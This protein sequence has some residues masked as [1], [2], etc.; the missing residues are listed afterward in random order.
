M[1]SAPSRWSVG[2]GVQA[3]MNTV[4]DS[5]AFRYALGLGVLLSLSVLQ[6][7]P[8]VWGGGGGG[9]YYYSV[10]RRAASPHHPPQG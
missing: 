10:K 8:K 7:L 1:D 4:Y 6:L 3:M 5:Q 2:M 9:G